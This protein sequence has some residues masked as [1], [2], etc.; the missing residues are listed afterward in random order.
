MESRFLTY[1]T[2]HKLLFN[3]ESI[4]VS[5]SG[6]ADSV[7]LLNLLYKLK[8]YFN[9]ILYIFHLNHNL[10]GY[11]SLR[12]EKFVREIGKKYNIP[13]IIKSVDVEKYSREEKL[14]IEEAGR[15]LRYEFLSKISNE[16]KIDKIVTAHHLNDQVETFFINLIRGRSLLSFEG[17]KIKNNKLVRP[18]MEF[19]K[20]EIL[21]YC[22]KNNLE[23]VQDS[24]NFD[25]NFLRNKVRNVL[26][27]FIFENFGDSIEKH[28]NEIM[29]QVKD[30]NCIIKEYTDN[31]FNEKVKKIGNG[32]VIPLTLFNENRFFRFEIYKKIYSKFCSYDYRLENLKMLDKFVLS[33]SSTGRFEFA[34]MIF[35][36]EYDNIAV[37]SKNDKVTDDKNLN[38]SLTVITECRVDYT[39]KKT[40]EKNI[41]YFDA[42]K[43]KYPVSIRY[44]KPGD[45]FFPIGFDKETKLK[46]FFINNKIPLRIRKSIPLLVDGEG[47][48]LWVIPFRIGDKAKITDKTVNVAECKVSF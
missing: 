18:L 16:K 1:I 7:C 30:V 35:F 3:N 38:I 44:F 9:F 2:E 15:K 26:L 17:I 14:T 21:E 27:P 48:I 32:L 41:A 46:K 12:D 6:G 37:F 8:N 20:K 5:F 19:G 45:K 10:R 23:F 11:E 34:N 36:K 25:N 31:L 4:L 22:K 43:I 39:E 28:T 42:D 33:K 40:N 13:V 24:S 47:D 29:K